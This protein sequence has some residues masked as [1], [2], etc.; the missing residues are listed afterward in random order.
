MCFP[1]GFVS[2][3]Q[4]YIKNMIPTADVRR[5]C[6]GAN[7]REKIG[8]W[9]GQPTGKDTAAR[10]DLGVA[11][12]NILRGT[13]KFAVEVPAVNYRNIIQTAWD[14]MPHKFDSSFKPATNGVISLNKW[15]LTFAQTGTRAGQITIQVFGY[16][17]ADSA[18]FTVTSQDTVSLVTSGSWTTFQCSTSSNINIPAGSTVSAVDVLVILFGGPLFAPLTDKLHEIEQKI[19][20]AESQNPPIPQQLQCPLGNVLPPSI[21]LNKNVSSLVS[22]QK[23][24]FNYGRLSL[25][26]NAGAAV[27][28]SFSMVPRTPVATIS[29][30]CV[31]ESFQ[32]SGKDIVTYQFRVDTGDLVPPLTYKWSNGGAAVATTAQWAVNTMASISVTVTDMD[33]LSATASLK[34]GAQSCDTGSPGHGPV[35]TVCSKKPWTP[36]C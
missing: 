13:E 8:I 25:D 26:N 27:G 17:S 34:F 30:K 3:L 5:T 22:G 31:S 32:A 11:A 2:F 23:L 7:P 35:D 4:N 16:D 6:T 20:A 18:S 28:G 10:R 29:K 14:Q 15:T 21:P 9:M 33:N 19:A 1:D 24:K 36:G 12:I